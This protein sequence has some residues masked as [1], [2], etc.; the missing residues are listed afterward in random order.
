MDQGCLKKIK[1]R[2]DFYAWCGRNALNKKLFVHKYFID[3]S[4]IKNRQLH[5]QVPIDVTGMPCCIQSMWRKPKGDQEVLHRF[6]I[7][8][9]GSHMPAHE[10]LVHFIANSF[11]V[12]VKCLL[13]SRLPYHAA[14]VGEPT[15]AV[16]IT[17]ETGSFSHHQLRLTVAP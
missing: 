5:C 14:I 2:M 11:A 10:F 13:K 9:C 17:G 4:C 8:E 12:W 7:Y 3:A 16:Y 15:I 1:E 6:N